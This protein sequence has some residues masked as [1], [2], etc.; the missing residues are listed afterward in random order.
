M[1]APVASLPTGSDS[2]TGPSASAMHGAFLSPYSVPPAPH[3]LSMPPASC[4]PPP[5]APPAP[6][7][8]AAAARA[9]RA[10]QGMAAAA[11]AA[12][13]MQQPPLERKHSAAAG[14]RSAR[15]ATPQMRGGGGADER[16]SGAAAAAAATAPSAGTRRSRSNS[17]RYDKL[18]DTAAATQSAVSSPIRAATAAVEGRVAAAGAAEAAA[19]APREQRGRARMLSEDDD[20]DDADA[21]LD[22]CSGG[23]GAKRRRLS[24]LTADER[25][26]ASRDRNREHA[27][28]TRLRKKA[29][30]EELKKTVE[31]LERHRD[32]A[33]R[34]AVISA[35]RRAE[36][37]ALR[38]RVV[39]AFLELRGGGGSKGG[40][41]AADEAR[42]WRPLVDDAFVLQHA[43]LTCGGGGSKSPASSRLTGIPHVLAELAE[44]RALLDGVAGSSAAAAP[45]RDRAAARALPLPRVRLAYAVDAAGMTVGGTTL[46][47]PWR[48]T[49]VGAVACGARAELVMNGGM[50]RATFTPQNRLASLHMVFD[51]APF[52]AALSAAVP[53]RSAPP[54]AAAAG[55]AVV[56][57]DSDASG[58]RCSGSSG[59]AECSV[60]A[61]ALPA[62]R[63]RHPL[64]EIVDAVRERRSASVCFRASPSG[65]A[66]A[67]GG[68]GGSDGGGAPLQSLQV[69]PMSAQGPDTLHFVGVLQMLP[70][71]QTTH[72]DA[73]P[74]PFVGYT[75]LV[76]SATGAS[77][78]SNAQHAGATQPADDL[79]GGVSGRP[80]SR[81]SDGGYASA[82]DSCNDFAFLRDDDG[83]GGSSDDGGDMDDEEDTGD[84]T[85]GDNAGSG[86]GS[87]AS[88]SGGGSGG[89]GG[90]VTAPAAHMPFLPYLDAGASFGQ[91]MSG[92]M[93]AYGWGR[94]SGG[95]V[96]YN[97]GRA[98][99]GAPFNVGAAALALHDFGSGGAASDDGD[100]ASL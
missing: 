91:G 56:S 77:S 61:A 69:F 47:A 37:D 81:L 20:D 5:S 99:E 14:R 15:P 27:R 43:G 62:R 86:R 73:S 41:A 82:S 3:L 52:A 45:R 48:A 57:S 88:S 21:H 18:H 46:M 4:A 65:G 53:S 78:S 17:L 7:P 50:L 74:P 70:E 25:A 68:G 51:T 54:T 28:N 29:Y 26:Q 63:S 36:A 80:A 55:T 40:A 6:P 12:A 98:G 38:L 94:A 13:L 79:T 2:L 22:G 87:P 84:N 16:A 23:G 34:E 49:T 8:P 39:E 100:G 71:Q 9:T 11:A 60:T 67:A 30:V 44:L 59:G 32:W 35:Q 42:A 1:A 75:E 89:G 58:R 33:A 64:D 95:A 83:G 85:N 97:A 76:A 96:D 31:E 90:G 24:A 19:A 66:V 92:A 72:T 93:A 10:A